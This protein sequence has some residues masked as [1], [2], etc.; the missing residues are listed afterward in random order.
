MEWIMNNWFNVVGILVIAVGA[1]FAGKK[2][3]DKDKAQKIEAIREWLKYGVTVTE[4]ALGS[5]TGK[6]KLT[7]LWS[8]ATQQFPFIAK[9][10]TFE[11][12]SRMVDEALAWMKEQ[13]E[14]NPN[15]KAAI[16]GVQET[17]VQ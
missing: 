10:L 6:L 5:N 12:F 14:T 3:M 15:I 2:F 16:L 9:L 7:M 1:I 13:I 11:D 4:R 17:E 8:I